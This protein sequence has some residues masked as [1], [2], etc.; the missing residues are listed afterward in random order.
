MADKLRLETNGRVTQVTADRIWRIGRS[1]ESD[2]VLDGE[3]VSRMHAELRPSPS[4]W[5][6]VDVGSQF[7]TYL[8]QRP[9]KEVRVDAPMQVRF[10]LAETGAVLSITTAAADRP[11]GSAPAPG[12]STQ[13][14]P[15]RPVAPAPY[16]AAPAVSPQPVKP[17]QQPPAGP[18]AGA[19]PS[20]AGYAE[21]IRIPAVPRAPETGPEL[22]VRVAGNERRFPHPTPV[23]IGRQPDSTVVVSDPTCS[24][25][26]L[27][28]E[29]APGSW[30]IRNLSAEGT[31]LNGRP[32][33]RLPLAA[34]IA[35][36]L[37]HPQAGTLVELA[38]VVNGVPVPPS[39]PA[40]PAA[41][42]PAPAP[43]RS[44]WAWLAAA[45]VLILLV[46][47]GGLIWWNTARQDSGA[48]GRD[49]T[50]SAG[51]T[52]TLATLSGEELDGAKVAM[53][54]IEAESET[55]SGESVRWSG[56]GTIIDSS[57]LIL[58]NAHV[59]AP[60]A[61][62]LE[63][64]YG[65]IDLVDP[66]ELQIS[67]IES[68]D[69]T[70]A[71]PTYLARLVA[72]DGHVDAAVIEIYATID[73]DPLPEE[74]M[75]LPVMPIGDS[76]DLRTGDDVT[77]LGFPGISQSAGVSVT[78]GVISTFVD[79]PEGLGNRAEIDTDARIAP[80]NSGGAAIDNDARL[81]GIPTAIF[82]PEGGLVPSGRIRPIN[83]VLPLLEEAGFEAPAEE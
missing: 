81:I 8:D 38:P 29:P 48:G 11:G 61:E 53:V 45:A 71:A 41:A 49:S 72:A 78:R 70:P 28:I 16:G 27:V 34:T 35:V 80:G 39:S 52:D 4:G 76:D 56:S 5:V 1:L 54:R 73:G 64:L 6:L 21:T 42:G 44:G 65:P 24:R 25:Q 46:A 12:Q 47:G 83:L 43:R 60:E 82:A 15:D 33:D 36:R 68:P 23:V 51:E 26:H 75:G 67:L 18:P 14:R 10:G 79:D 40:A 19:A 77:V 37:G 7:G 58:T 57:G 30:V 32:I 20:G 3:S 69:D 31:F 59:A 62:G 22:L 13:V 2:V 66:E 74:G 9:V 17:P 63:E 50:P 55:T